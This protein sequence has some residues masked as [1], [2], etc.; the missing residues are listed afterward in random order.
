MSMAKFIL[1]KKLNMTQIW[2]GDKIIP[3][4][5]VQAGPV[6]V[7]QLRNKEKDG[8][9]AVQVGFL[10][11]AKKTKNASAF[12]YIREFRLKEGG[13]ADFEVGAK[14]DASV[15]EEGDKIKISGLSKGRGFQGVVKRHNFGGGRKTHGMKDR[16]RAPGS[17]GSTAP[18]RVVP[19]RK[20]AGHMGQERTSVKKLTVAAVDADKGI[21]FIKG[22]VPGMKGALVEIFK[23]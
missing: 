15:F 23:Q 21:I 10:E 12:R 1:G 14:I 17:I 22:A 8:Y 4:T 19:G 5:A 18:Q 7:S 2:K 3:V 20:M 13:A 6:V 11:K 16:Y 9:E